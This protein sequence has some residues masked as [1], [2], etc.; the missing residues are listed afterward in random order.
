MELEENSIEIVEDKVK[1]KVC[2]VW[3]EEDDYGYYDRTFYLH[4]IVEL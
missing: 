1:C 2:D 4:E 3:D